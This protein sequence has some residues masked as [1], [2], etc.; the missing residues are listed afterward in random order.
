M[1]RIVCC[2]EGML[3]LARRGSRWDLSY[4]G[5]TLNTAIHLAG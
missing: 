4:G 5:D 2:G 1:T 3:E